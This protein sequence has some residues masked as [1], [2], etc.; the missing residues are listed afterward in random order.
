MGKIQLLNEQV[1]SRIAAG[2]VVERPASIV[3][4]LVENA[5]DAMAT[6]I[7][8]RIVDGGVREI[9]V[10][11]NGDGIAPEDMPLSIVK[12]ATSKIY[13]LADLEH[14]HTMGF[15]GEALSSIAAVSML[16]I[17][18][19]TRQSETGTELF[20]R[21]GKIEYIRQAGLPE[22]TTVTVENLFYNT[23]ARLKFLKRYGTEAAVISD[24][25]VRLVLARPDI[26]FRYSIADKTVLHSPGNG[27]L[28]DAIYTV[29][30][31]SLKDALLELSYQWNDLK[32]SG[33]VGAPGFKYKTQKQG[34]IFINGRYI[35]DALIQKTILQ[36]YGERLLKGDFPFYVLKIEMPPQ[37]FDVNV[38]PNKLAVHF[39]DENE[40]SYAVMNAIGE[41]LHRNTVSPVLEVGEGV[42]NVP[43][44]PPR[45]EEDAVGPLQKMDADELNEAVDDVLRRAAQTSPH[46]YFMREPTPFETVEKEIKQEEIARQM[47]FSSPDEKEKQAPAKLLTQVSDYRVIGVAF[48][49]YIIVE[50]GEALYFIDQH[51]AHE[52]KIYDALIRNAAINRVSQRLLVPVKMSVSAGETLLIRENMDIMKE[53]G[54]MVANL[55]DFSCDVLAV[56]QILGEVDVRTVFQD[57]VAA[58][59]RGDVSPKL[60]RD[61]IAKGACK[62]AV[63]AGNKM[64]DADIRELVHTIITSGSIPHCPHG[65][66][67]AIS[68]TRKQLEIGFRRRV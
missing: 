67:V 66:P 47:A 61:K 42:G 9:R 2:E 12:H 40:L 58:L 39:R 34:S 27:N 8:V 3:K 6:A 25:L 36:A 65:R 16:T 4:E 43:P 60:R 5:I 44:T 48:F 32:I 30:G 46:V 13:S 41:A 18:S 68:V 56:P 35:R 17:K 7:S 52:R 19:R 15:R 21:G 31:F 64:S 33:Y 20:A 51:A 1:S 11:D 24:I 59:E 29:Y 54:F 14:I 50:T 10:A 28:D 53:M 26:S 63:K 23:P 38:H 22:G 55:S 45:P 62:R 57:I 49:G 37:D